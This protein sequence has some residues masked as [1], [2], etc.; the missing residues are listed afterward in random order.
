MVK[1]YCYLIVNINKC[2]CTAPPGNFF[3]VS[4]FEMQRLVLNPVR[5]SPSTTRLLKQVVQSQELA[6]KQ[7]QKSEA[8]TSFMIRPT[9]RLNFDPLKWYRSKISLTQIKIKL[10]TRTL[11]Q[12][13]FYFSR[14]CNY[15]IYL[16]IILINS[17][18]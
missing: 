1:S 11:D 8:F 17:Y 14:Y 18:T 7:L 3:V 12:K 16:Y 13:S 9:S 6:F 4:H 10:V 15:N 2:V 5:Q